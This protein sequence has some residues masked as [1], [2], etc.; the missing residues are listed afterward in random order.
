[1]G[2]STN[3]DHESVRRNVR[4]F[5]AKSGTEADV[6]RIMESEPG[7]DV[8][9][10]A[11][12]CS[13]LGVAAI[14]IPE[15]LGGAGFGFAELAVVLEELGAA[16]YP[17]PLFASRVLAAEALIR[18]GDETV[19]DAVAALAGGETI[20]CL[21]L[22]EDT[23]TWQADRISVTATPVGDGYALKGRASFVVD[24]AVADLV[25]VVADLAGEPSLFHVR[26]GAEGLEREPL[27]TVDLTRRQARLTFDGCIARLV[28]SPGT[29]PRVVDSVLDLAAIALA[30]EQVGG[31]QR[32]LDL[33]VDHAKNRIQF[34]RPIGSFQAIKH[35]CANVLLELD[36]AR[37]AARTAAWSVDNAP[38]DIPVLASV[39]K[40]HCSEM[41]ELA[42]RE[43]IQIH[44]GMGFTWEFAAQ[45]YF[46][47]AY[48][49]ALMFGT[50]DHHREALARRLGLGTR[51]VA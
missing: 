27:Q 39:A 34:G 33:A 44:G 10:W 36:A 18:S 7:H 29:A 19:A 16:L 51:S 38:D 5:L 49:S 23:G 9:G 37:S 46:K 12:L 17:S 26:S 21:A 20:G 30:A 28:G 8:V 48:S 1:M 22:S 43:C 4:S 47:R 42:A 45:L 3:E 40:A 11:K 25:V 31:A 50:P 32:C 6:R 41:Y 15:E 24:G 14:G 2:F 35:K 13:E